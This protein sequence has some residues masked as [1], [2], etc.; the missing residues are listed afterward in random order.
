MRGNM[1]AYT[2]SCSHEFFE[3]YLRVFKTVLKKQKIWF[4]KTA[5]ST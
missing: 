2:E 1:E 3:T 5:F 4:L